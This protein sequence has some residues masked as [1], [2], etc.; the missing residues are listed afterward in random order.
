[1]YQKS[2]TETAKDVHVYSYK[3]S[4]WIYYRHGSILIAKSSRFDRFHA[5]LDDIDSHTS[6][7]QLD[8]ELGITQCA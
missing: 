7:K 6:F 4:S 1:M 8:Y 5:I 2:V 3:S